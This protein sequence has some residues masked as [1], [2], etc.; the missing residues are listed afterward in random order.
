MPLIPGGG[1]VTPVDPI[2]PS[3]VISD[4]Y[5]DGL[6]Y[7]FLSL[8]RYAKIMGLD[9]LH[10]YQSVSALK[11]TR[12]C[13]DIIYEY[14]WQDAAYVGRQDILQAIMQAEN[15]IINEI[16]YYPAPYWN[17]D[18][19]QYPQVY[20]PEM[21]G[22]YGTDTRGLFKSV[23]TRLGYVISGGI[24]AVLQVDSTDYARQADIDID[25][26]TYDEFAVWN[27]TGV[28]G[29][30]CQIQAYFKVYAV[31]DEENC[32]TDPESQ[33]ADEVWRIRDIR[34]KYNSATTVA[35]VYIP[36]WQLIKPSLQRQ[37]NAGIIDAD[38]AD[39]Y[40]DDIEFYLVYNDTST[41]AQFLW[42]NDISCESTAC[43]WA[44]Q[45]GCMLV[46]DARNGLVMPQPS[47]YDADTETF[48]IGGFSECVEP[49]KVRLWYY[50]GAQN[51]LSRGCDELAQPWA[52]L[53]AMLATS[54]LEK[55]LC[56]CD[57]VMRKQELWQR[58]TAM[59]IP[60]TV[61]FITSQD[62]SNPF[63][64]RYGEVM[65][66]RRLKQVGRKRGRAIFA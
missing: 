18:V 57:N 9:P 47:T 58:D 53:I 34:I 35:T 41:Q 63:G 7:T 46:K 21:Y 43:A 54:R 26:D 59:N 22:I 24:R 1:T 49:N 16:G 17:C 33:G 23:K 4:G 44:V 64:T 11:P 65:V 13:N 3:T 12:Q 20:K 62:L 14:G 48:T 6:T 8:P 56:S 25:K 52:E 55:P 30:T 66:W 42:A 39:S 10:F 5:G 28:T 40:V 2:I 29:D 50:S 27:I 19:V 60:N 51:N 61:S 32:R 45:D 38:D 36:R 15:D 37:I 31:G